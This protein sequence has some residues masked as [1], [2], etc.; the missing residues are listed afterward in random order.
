MPFK[1]LA[2]TTVIHDRANNP[3]HIYMPHELKAE[4][5][6][7]QTKTW[8]MVVSVYEFACV[9]HGNLVLAVLGF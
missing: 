9:F 1:H 3:Y 7:S 2:L 4:P 8:Y 6:L 5:L